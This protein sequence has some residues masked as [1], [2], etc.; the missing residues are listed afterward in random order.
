MVASQSRPL[1]NPVQDGDVHMAKSEVVE[2]APSAVVTPG[3]LPACSTDA[4]APTLHVMEKS[5]FAPPAVVALGSLPVGSSP[6]CAAA[7][8]Y[9][10]L[11]LQAP[12][13]IVAPGRLPVSSSSASAAVQWHANRTLHVPRIQGRCSSIKVLL[14]CAGPD[15]RLLS[16]TNLLRNQGMLGEN[17]DTENGPRFDITDD[18]N[19]D[20][21][22]ARIRLM[23]F[24]AVFASPPCTTASRLRNI[25][26]GPPPL[27]GLVGAS[28]YGLSGLSVSNKE[29][30]RLH[31]LIA[32]RVAQVLEFV[33]V[34]G[35]PWIFETPALKDGEVSVLRLDEFQRL[36]EATGVEHNIGV[37]C[38]FGALS[39]K[40]TSWVSYGVDLHDM[41]TECPHGKRTWFNDRTGVAV[42]SRHRPTAGRDTFS[43]T[44]RT[45]S[46]TGTFVPTNYV[47][48][49]LAAYPD[50]LNRY[51]V[52]KLAAGIANAAAQPRMASPIMMNVAPRNFSEDIEWRQRLRG[53]VEVDAKAEANHRAIGGMRNAAQALGKLHTVQAFGLALGDDIRKVLLDELALASSKGQGK[54]AWIHL[55]CD[56]IG[57]TDKDVRPPQGAID[58]VKR[59]LL[60]HVGGDGASL[61]KAKTRINSTIL[62]DWRRKSGDPDVEVI[63]WLV[64]GAPA[65]ILT[66]PVDSA[67]IFPDC[68][69]DAEQS[70]DTLSTDCD[71]FCN[72]SGVEEHA[73]TEAELTQHIEKGHIASFDS[74]AALRAFVQG[75][76]VLS[77]LGLILKTRNGVT[78]ARMILDTKASGIKYVTGKSQRV[79]LPRLFD[80][81]L[82]LL[83][84][85]SIATA[86]G[87][88]VSAFLLDFTDAFWQVPIAD[89]ELRFFCVTSLIKGV[90]KYMAFLRAAQGS[91]AAPLLWAR[92]AAL[93]MRLTQSLFRPEDV[94]LMC[95]VDDPLAALR[96]TE[97]E[98]RTTVAVIILVWEALD[99]KLAYHKGQ[100][101]KTVTWIGGT[102]TCESTG[103]RASV[104]ASIVDDVRADLKRFLKVNVISLKELHSLVGK[105]S[106]CAGLLITLRPFLQTLW[107]ALYS[108]Q[109]MGSPPSTVWTKQIAPTLQWIDTFFTGAVGGIERYF[110]LDAYL[111][112]GPTIEIGTDASP[113][114]LGGWLSRDGVITHFFAS[115]ITAE[116][117]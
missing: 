9:A 114:G 11:T 36:L 73:V 35:R 94:N 41:P 28:R 85:L 6:P 19:W 80:A 117:Q 107:A 64:E 65:G 69:A 26:G 5:V 89:N 25:P 3:C 88:E 48:A 78:K 82:R 86:A 12:S 53:A 59:V 39:P 60:K 103:V 110:R 98:R 100:F 30:V 115:P 8:R 90:R 31:N 20:P 43:D 62:G 83:F 96:G 113:W 102:L 42:S 14:L 84:L 91:R 101:G 37:Q 24:A 106:Y 76:P 52:A 92:L 99:L 27:R 51:L 74:I 7:H 116:D 10:N 49:Q 34:Q 61:P 46:A 44:Q 109:P 81:V 16:I 2:A 50:L 21:L 33:T 29:L 57:A 75:D 87:G 45:R 54:T 93:L 72:Y 15:G 55:T 104:K 47:S 23:E 71:S 70:L 40:P 63:P 95:F 13:S 17:W 77:K 97:L 38:T 105:L 79:T 18:A 22:L 58:A 56:I 4:S 108:D 111:R 66:Q 67:G 32:V 68:S 1:G 112:Q